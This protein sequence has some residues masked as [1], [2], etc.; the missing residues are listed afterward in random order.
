MTKVDHVFA[1]SSVLFQ[2]VSLLDTI[3]SICPDIRRKIPLGKS[4]FGMLHM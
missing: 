2:L 4:S 1:K 3:H